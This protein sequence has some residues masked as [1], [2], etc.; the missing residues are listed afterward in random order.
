MIAAEVR[1]LDLNVVEAFAPGEFHDSARVLSVSVAVAA[2]VW[3]TVF[4]VRCRRQFQR[5]RCHR[6]GE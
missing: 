2:L 1:A 4:A 3:S 6:R 5:H